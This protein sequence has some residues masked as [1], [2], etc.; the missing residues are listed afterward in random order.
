MTFSLIALDP[1]SGEMAAGIASKSLCVGGICVYKQP[2]TGIVCTQA[3]TSRWIGYRGILHLAN[4]LTPKQALDTE[5][6][7][8]REPEQ[9]QCHAMTFDGANAAHTGAQCPVWAGHDALPNLTVAGNCLA[10]EGVVQAMIDTFRRTMGLPVAERVLRALEEADAAGG[11]IR[12]RQS[13]ALY[14]INTYDDHTLDLRVDD[15]A[16][17]L[18]HLRRLYE[19]AVENGY[20]RPRQAESATG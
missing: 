5:L 14:A 11:D 6:G 15:D 16:K 18:D 12:G 1:A 3:R 20:Y 17:P 13:A 7:S 9:R 10:G 4:G 8:D 19:H 2:G